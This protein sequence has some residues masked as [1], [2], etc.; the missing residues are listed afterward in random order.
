MLVHMVAAGKYHDID[1]ARLELLK[2]LA[3]EPSLRTSVASDYGNGALIRQRRIAELAQHGSYKVEIT[4]ADHMMTQGLQAFKIVD[5]LYLTRRTSDI[6]VLLHT[7][8]EGTC[9]EFGD[10]HWNEAQVPVLYE[11]Q[12]GK[13]A[14]LY[15]TLGHCRGHYDLQPLA[16]FY[17]HPE[18]C[19]WNYP[20][21]YELLRRALRWSMAER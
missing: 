11:R 9:P 12:V 4:R 10:Y 17:P 2:L 21:Y 13:G 18:R 6:D 19:A 15:L 3:E 1:F 8:Y 7:K 5:E 16:N 14:I 20:I